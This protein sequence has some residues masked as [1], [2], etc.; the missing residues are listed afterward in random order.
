VDRNGKDEQRIGTGLLTCGFDQMDRG[1]SI[2]QMSVEKEKKDDPDARE[3]K[4]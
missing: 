3:E 1:Y 4:E 2:S